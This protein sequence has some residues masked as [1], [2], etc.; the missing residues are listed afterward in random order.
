MEQPSTET[1]KPDQKIKKDVPKTFKREAAVVF[2]LALFILSTSAVWLPAA[3]EVLK[4]IVYPFM[5]FIGLCFGLDSY[6]KQ[7]KK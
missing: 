1:D 6:S 4:I 3:L 5:T 2:A 7:I